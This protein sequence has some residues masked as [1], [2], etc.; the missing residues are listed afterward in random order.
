MII[1]VKKIENS[2]VLVFPLIKLTLILLLPLPVRTC[3]LSMQTYQV[4]A[5]S[6]CVSETSD[7]HQHTEACCGNFIQI[8]GQFAEKCYYCRVYHEI[9]DCDKCFCKVMK[10]SVTGELC[11]YN[12]IDEPF[13]TVDVCTCDMTSGPVVNWNKNEKVRCNVH[14]INIVPAEAQVPLLR[15]LGAFFGIR[16]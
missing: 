11:Y 1:Q 9:D 8:I 2:N 3:D 6:T 5:S 14:K 13:Q 16:S 12:Y 15:R 7:T 10:C 4:K